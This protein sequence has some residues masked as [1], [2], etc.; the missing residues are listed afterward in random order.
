MSSW[1]G[2]LPAGSTRGATGA[3]QPR[4]HAWSASCDAR[5]GGDGVPRG[6]GGGGGASCSSS[7]SAPCCREP[8]R[9]SEP[10]VFTTARST[11]R[12]RPLPPP[13]RRARCCHRDSSARPTDWGKPLPPAPPPR[14]APSCGRGGSP[15][16][17]RNH[18]P[19]NPKT[20]RDPWA[21]H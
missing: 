3:V 16:H 11:G 2:S 7:S 9:A 19:H 8:F 17:P 20:S 14:L 12:G 18:R 6:G 4:V 15:H 10:S 21:T 13:P 5:P 1:E